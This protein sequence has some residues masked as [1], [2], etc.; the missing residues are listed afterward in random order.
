[1]ENQESMVCN[2]CN[3]QGG[4]CGSRNSCGGNYG[5]GRGNNHGSF[6][7]RLI[8]GLFIIGMVFS[9]GVKIGEFKGAYG[10]PYGDRWM[11]HGS[12]KTYPMQDVM[13]NQRIPVSSP[14]SN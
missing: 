10:D 1:M 11:M 5:C 14:L 13:F 3:G 9:L 8:L 4:M 12:Y 2:S 7:L 6:L